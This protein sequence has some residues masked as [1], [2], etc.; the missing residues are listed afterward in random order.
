MHTKYGAVAK[1]YI[2]QDEQLNIP[3]MQKETSDGSNVFVDERNLDQ[4]KNMGKPEG[5]GQVAG[6]LAGG[7][8]KRLEL[9]TQNIPKAMIDIFGTP[10]I[11]RQL[12]Y[13]KKQDGKIHI[14]KEPLNMP[15]L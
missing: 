3:S 10:F 11:S 13:L 5:W 4:L 2:V 9:K 12:N 15:L 8:G 14:P 7:L 1:A 6:L